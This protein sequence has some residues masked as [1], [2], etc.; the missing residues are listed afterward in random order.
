MPEVSA[1]MYPPV[2]YAMP[3][4]PVWAGTTS[5]QMGMLVSLHVSVSLVAKQL[6][7]GEAVGIF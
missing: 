3:R 2:V 1:L 5:Y 6:F 4:L 7:K